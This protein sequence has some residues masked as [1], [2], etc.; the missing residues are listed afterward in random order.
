[1]AANSARDQQAAKRSWVILLYFYLAALV[2]LG[3][4]VTGITMALFG[5]KDA[6]FPGLGLSRYE[7][8]YSVPQHPDEPEEKLT[9]QELQAAKERAT[10]D[11]RNRGLDGVLNGLIITGVG[12]PVL[13]WH[14]KRGRALGAGAEQPA[15]PAS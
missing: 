15:A 10:E 7:Y 1:M 11:R 13:I 8:E 4:V 9:E 14:L 2:G 3:F 6:L 12:A 5:A